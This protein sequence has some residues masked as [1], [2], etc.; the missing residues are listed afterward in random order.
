MVWHLV[1]APLDVMHQTHSLRYNLRPFGQIGKKTD[2]QIYFHLHPA[3]SF[4]F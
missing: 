2:Q 4:S 3:L 1:F